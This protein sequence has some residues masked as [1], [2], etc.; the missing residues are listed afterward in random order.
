MSW[1]EECGLGLDSSFLA[2]NSFIEARVGIERG[3]VSVPTATHSF[4]E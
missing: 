4:A 3:I 2:M 1:K